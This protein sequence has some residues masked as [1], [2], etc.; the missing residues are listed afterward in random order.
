M[1]DL[2]NLESIRSREK[3]LSSYSEEEKSALC[4]RQKK[5]KNVRFFFF[6][7]KKRNHIYIIRAFK[8]EETI[9]SSSE[10]NKTT[11]RKHVFFFCDCCCYDA[12]GVRTRAQKRRMGER[13]LWDV[14]VNNDDISFT[15]HSSEIEWD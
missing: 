6:L 13:D 15:T 12:L 1:R 8:E 3:D 7:K 9:E 5:G 14:I 11:P 4:Q 10:R 2:F